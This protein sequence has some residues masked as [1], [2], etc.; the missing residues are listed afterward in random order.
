MRIRGGVG[1][2]VVANEC[3]RGLVASASGKAAARRR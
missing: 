3:W 2:V 1:V